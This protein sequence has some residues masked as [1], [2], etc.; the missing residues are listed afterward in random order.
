MSTTTT[1]THTGTVAEL[2]AAFGRGDVPAVLEYLSD[3]ISWDH[4]LRA[5][6][7]PWMQPRTGKQ[8]V[9]E[10]FG[11]LAQGMS[12]SVFDPQVIAA[13]GD[14][15]V[16]VLRIAGSIIS[17]GN[18]VEEDLWVHVWTFDADG[19]VASFR[20]IGDLAREE[21]PFRG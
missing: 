15:V 8:Q 10:F 18:P 14:N 1:S 4:G 16:A 20:H 7:L 12:L 17:N 9:E 6:D 5:N 11:I 2:Y 19:K 3:N 21:I 13:D